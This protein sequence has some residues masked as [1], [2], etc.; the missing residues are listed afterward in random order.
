MNP[1]KLSTE[2]Q[3][4]IEVLSRA[5]TRPYTQL[6]RRYIE[7]AANASIIRQDHKH[8]H[9]VL[10]SAIALFIATTVAFAVLILNNALPSYTILA[11]ALLV[12]ALVAAIAGAVWII[13]KAAVKDAVRRYL[14]EQNSTT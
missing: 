4:Y 12:E 14:D 6:H 2:H 8:L 3:Q 7:D 1:Y 9:V 5:Y 10:V 11:V 13:Q